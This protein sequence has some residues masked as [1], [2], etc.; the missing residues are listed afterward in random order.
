MHADEL[1]IDEDLVR[2]LLADQF[3]DWAGLEPSIP[4]PWGTD[5]ALFRLGGQLSVR[6]PRTPGSAGQVEKDR[7]W[8]PALAPHLPLALPEQL[9]LGR[10]GRGYP[11]TWG[12]YRWLEGE[13]AR[14][15]LLADPVAEARSLAGFLK[16]LQ[17]LDTADAPRP[18]PPDFGRGAALAHRDETVRKAL[19]LLGEQGRPYARDAAAA[20]KASLDAAEHDGPPVWLHGDLLPGNLLV[21]DGAITAVIDCAGLAAGDP[22]VDLLP[23]WSLLRGESRQAFRAAVGAD[24]DEDLW[25]R[26]RGWAVYVA[27]TGLSYYTE[28]NNPSFVALCRSLLSEVLAEFRPDGTG[29][30]VYTATKSRLLGW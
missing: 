24:R 21:R 6:L 19:A 16:A 10:P 3:P 18:G 26:G 29:Q 12:V 9:A 25:L 13:A 22:A 1:E 11:F 17:G 15:D 27:V 30:R 28:Q 7:R 5:N 4:G 2:G 23:A 8:L 14:F 20:W